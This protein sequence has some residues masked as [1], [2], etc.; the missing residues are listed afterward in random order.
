MVK[1][2]SKGKIYR[3][4]SDKTDEVYIGS[5]VET[6][7]RRFSIH[8]SYFKIG[9]YCSS[10]E[11]LKHGDARIELIK[12]FPCNSERELAKEEDKYILDCCKV[13]NCNRASRTVAEYYQENRAEIAAQQKRY[14]EAN[15][16]ERLEKFKQ[17][18]EANRERIS[19]IRNEKFDCPCGGKYTKKHKSQHEKSKK[20]QDWVQKK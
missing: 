18:R 4:V 7:E 2:Y 14:Y 17:Y 1:D 10:A 12:D 20:H 15:R 8:K 6:L 5:T 3:I 9:R 13:V 16:A 19:E 11:I